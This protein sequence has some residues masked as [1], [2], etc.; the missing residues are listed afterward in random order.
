VAL[1]AGRHLAFAAPGGSAWFAGCVYFEASL[2]AHAT[3]DKNRTRFML[4]HNKEDDIV[5]PK[6]AAP[7]F[8]VLL[9]RGRVQL[10]HRAGARPGDGAVTS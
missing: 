7:D 8:L 5:E 3:V 2:A 9:K 4:I 10:Q 1:P 6:R